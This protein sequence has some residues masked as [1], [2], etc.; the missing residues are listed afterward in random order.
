MKIKRIVAIIAAL[1]LSLSAAACSDTDTKSSSK[2]QSSAVSSAAEAAESSE[3]TAASKTEEES[4]Q[5]ASQEASKEEED[6]IAQRIRCRDQ[7]HKY[8]YDLQAF[9]DE[10]VSELNKKL[11]ASYVLLYD[12][13]E[14]KVLFSSNGEYSCYPASTTKLLTAITMCKIVD[15]PQ[16]VITVGNEVYLIDPQSSRAGLEPGMQLT[17]EMLMDALLLPSGNDAA[18]VMAVY[19]GRKYKNDE[20]LSDAMAIEA[21]MEV[22]NKI[23]ANIGT[24]RTHYVT[25]DGIHSQEHFTNAR[26][27]AVI[28]DY[29]RT[30][31]LIKNSVKKAEADWTLISGQEAYW[32]NT[33]LILDKGSQRYSEFCDGMKTGYTSEAGPSLIASATIDGHTLIAVMMNA[34]TDNSRFDDCNMIFEKGFALYGLNYTYK[35]QNS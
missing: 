1:C 16:T 4:V 27:L 8:I 7:N 30:I 24:T 3:E 10:T 29:A 19:G 32:Q 34:R 26:D 31:P 17:L 20:S 6:A 25:P 9:P 11:S 5:T 28:A 33:N 2:E 13:T 12:T 22:E 15:D 35:N 21:F 18:Y 14:D 23:A